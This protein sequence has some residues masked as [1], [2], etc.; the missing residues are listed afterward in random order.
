MKRVLAR[1]EDSSIFG[2][3]RLAV[4][5]CAWVLLPSC[6]GVGEDGVELD[7][8]LDAAASDPIV[9]GAAY[10]SMPAVGAL[11]IYNQ[12]A[13]T[14]TLIGPR[15]VLTAAHC[16]DGVFASSMRFVIGPNAAAPEHVL[17]VLG[18]RAHPDFDR[19]TLVN[20]IAYVTL[21]EDAPV[22]PKPVIAKASTAWKSSDLFFVGYGMT[23]GY[24]G[25]GP[26]GRRRGG[27]SF[28]VG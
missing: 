10:A 18:M 22:M 17:K 5:L 11:T 12:L 2:W 23:N 14:G 25:T 16:V 19:D 7:E 27:G 20:D 4:V 6:G 13:C 21:K 3:L 26:P 28:R 15:R 24:T 1:V 9:G 8:M